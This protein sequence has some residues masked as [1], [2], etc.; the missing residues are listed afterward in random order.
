MRCALSFA[1]TI[2]VLAAALVTIAAVTAR[3]GDRSLYPPEPCAPRVEIFLTH[4]GYHAELALPA[5]LLRSRRGA[6]AAAL[7]HV[8]PAPWVLVG[9]G[10]AR[11][12]REGGWSP[13]RIADALRTLWPDNPSVIRLTSLSRRPDLAFRSG[14]LPVELSEP[15]AERLLQRLDQS[16]R[17]AG[18]RPVLVPALQAGD[19]ASYFESV[20]RFSFAKTC[21]VWIGQLLNAAGLATAPMLELLPQGLMWKV[22]RQADARPC[23]QAGPR[24]ADAGGRA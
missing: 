10:D 24:A 13:R 14:V 3:P 5:A 16:F 7:D 18:G 20:E 12:Y 21:N 15:G 11:F 23:R 17:L 8:G 22:R 9:W 2:V 6:A 4:N 1:L 19:A